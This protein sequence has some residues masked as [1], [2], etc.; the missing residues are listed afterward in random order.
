MTIQ[1][2]IPNALAEDIGDGDHTSLA[3]IPSFAKSKAHLLVKENGI[4]AGVEIAKQIFKHVDDSL[5]VTVFIND[6]ATV[7]KGDVAFHVEGKAQ[8][9]LKAERLVLNC[10]QRMSGIAT[11]TKAIVTKLSGLPTKVLDTRKTTPGMRL[12]E[13]MAVKIGGGENHRFGLYDMIMIKDNHSDYAGGVVKAIVAANEYL[14]QHRLNLK[15]EV[16]ARNLEEV[17]QI[18]ATGAI[19]RIMLDNFS[20]ADLKTAVALIGGKYETEASGGITIETIREYALCGVDYISVGALTHSVKSMD[21]SLK[22]IQ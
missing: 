18:L 6:G 20:I 14:K 4:L 11:S 19:N 7:V 12:L 22:A 13:K 8:S 16:E 15:I 2:F 9:I 5:T 17:N 21:L 10:M 3:C 1:D